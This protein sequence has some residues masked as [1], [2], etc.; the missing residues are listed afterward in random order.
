[1]RYDFTLRGRGFSVELRG[2]YPAYRYVH[3]FMGS[4]VKRP[5]LSSDPV[6]TLLNSLLRRS[7]HGPVFCYACGIPCY[8]GARSV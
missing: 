7:R 4:H 5:A 2:R 3:D 1:M 8:R 6:M